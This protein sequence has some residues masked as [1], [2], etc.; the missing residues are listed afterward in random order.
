MKANIK[1]CT[2]LVYGQPVILTAETITATR[3]SIADNCKACIDEAKSG[4]VRVNDLP[5]YIVQKRH[6][7][8]GSLVGK[9]DH[10][11]SFLQKAVY[12]QTNECVPLMV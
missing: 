10:C 6:E 4:K 5:S 1:P 12:I 7:A 2:V 3:R 8:A 9:H 11:L